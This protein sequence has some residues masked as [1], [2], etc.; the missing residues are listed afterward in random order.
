MQSQ[1][2]GR[3]KR[4]PKRQRGGRRV[5]TEVKEKVSTKALIYCRVSSVLQATDGHGLDSQEHRCRIFAEQK[6]LQIIK[7]FH[8]SVTGGGDFWQR[9]AMR[10]LLEYVDAC[11]TES[12]TVI[13]DDLKRFARDTQFHW[14]LRTEFSAR[15]ITPACL[16]FNFEDTPEGGFIETIMAAQGELERKQNRRQVIQ[17]QKARMEAGYWPFGGK[18]GYTIVKDPAH[19]K[20]CRPNAEG[21]ILAEALGAFVNRIF[22]RRVDVCRFLVE[23][24]VWSG[25]VPERY[26]DKL[27]QIMKD[28]FYCGDIEYLAWQVERREGK[29][30]G[31]IDRDTYEYIQKLLK[32]ENSLKRVRWDI[33][34]DFPLRGLILCDHCGGRLTAAWSKKIFPYYVCHTK[35]C[36]RYGKSIRRKDIEEQFVALLQRNT[37]KTEISLLV[38]VVFERVW[39]QEINAVKAQEADDARKIQE[40]EGKARQLTE[41]IFAAK[42]P[43]VK[44]VYEKQLEDVAIKI[45]EKN[46][47]PI[48]QTDL[49]IPY[50]TALEKA[51]GLLKNP[52][53]VWQSVGLVEQ[54]TLFYF[55]FEEKLRYNQ[56][57]GYRTE[58]SPNAIRLFEDFVSE[59]SRDVEHGAGC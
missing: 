30:E 14:K 46:V 50:R 39:A 8:D 26:I 19:G 34:P 44:S 21:K 12:F 27:T 7:V 32:K 40:L 17:K 16:N 33:S 2:M 20:I 56:F 41:A 1:N 23:R 13:F 15:G 6:G 11:P 28:P 4:P 25:Q 24:H 43:Q 58:K 3:F 5:I 51:T 45:E 9:P 48:T 31:I 52:Y 37:L 49:S 54:H 55:V 10:E 36:E 29:H 53:I 38:D 57:S 18:K 59:N 35:T 42:S 47:Q 22:L